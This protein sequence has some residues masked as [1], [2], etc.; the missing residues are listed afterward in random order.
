MAYRHGAQG[1]SYFNFAY[2]R[3]HGSAGRGPF[4][5]PP[6]DAIGLAKNR[7]FVAHAPQHFFLAKGWSD[8]TQLRDPLAGDTVYAFR[9]YAEPPADGWKTGFRFRLLTRTPIGTRRFRVTFNGRE[10]EET[11][12]V[13]EPYPEDA[14]YRPMH[15]D[16]GTLRAWTVARDAVCPGENRITVEWTSPD[17]KEP[18]RV[19]YMDLFPDEE[20]KG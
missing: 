7:E 4:N 6:F 15:G 12:C 9:M 20:G 10:Q 5:E 1:L 17:T 11:D 19:D 18:I 3:E 2:Y 14:R 8:K 13:K 16:A